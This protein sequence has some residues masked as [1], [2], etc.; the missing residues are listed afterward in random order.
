MPTTSLA[1]VSTM[2]A[3]VAVVGHLVAGAVPQDPADLGAVGG[4]GRESIGIGPVPAVLVGGHRRVVAQ[5]Q[6]RGAQTHTCGLLVRE[7]SLDSQVN[8][9][10]RLPAERAC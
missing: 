10:N 1:S 2:P 6:S 9:V 8:T 3:G 7:Q 4:V 5:P